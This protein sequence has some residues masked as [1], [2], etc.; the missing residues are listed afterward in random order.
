MGG[1]GLRGGGGGGDAGAVQPARRHRG[2]LA[3]QLRH[4]LRIEFFGDEIDSLR[5]FDPSTQ[6]TLSRVEQAWIG[7]ASE[8]LPR[9]G[10]AVAERLNALDLSGCHPPARNEYESE[11]A[12]L[13]AGSGFRNL[14]W[15]IPYLYSRPA[16]LLDYLP[17]SAPADPRGR[18]RVGRCAVGPG[19]PGGAGGARSALRGDIP[20]NAE[21][22]NF[23]SAGRC[24]SSYARSRPCS[25][26][27][28]TLDGWATAQRR[29]WRS[30]S[31]PPRFG[32]QVKN[33]I[34]E[35]ER[36][37]RAATGGDA[38]A[39]A[40]RLADLWGQAGHAI[41]P[42]D[43]LQ[44]PPPAGLTLVQGVMEEGWNFVWKL[45]TGNWMIEL[46][47]TSTSCP[48]SQL[49]VPHRRGGLRLGQ[50]EAATAATARAPWRPRCS[51]PMSS[52]AI[53]WCTSSTASAVPGP[54]QDAWTGWSASTCR[55]ITRR[56][57]SSTCPSIRPTGWRATSARAR[58]RRRCT[59]WARPTGSR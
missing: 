8:A 1:V 9:L 12:Q 20:S 57:T 13:V 55:S 10:E 17:E 44:T 52:R 59:G 3:A 48:R 43:N 21:A 53:T 29:R 36:E 25:L 38:L 14:E 47:A 49:L 34:A 35:V 42:V 24:A 32:G 22:P 46:L 11:I 37:S 56:A 28:S 16:S 30:I 50:A 4:P 31:P 27:H 40:P 39:Q 41:V 45:E 51:S 15:Y 5:T 7:P 6:R 54:D 2:H 19:R 18:R 23:T 33:V 26:G 58:R